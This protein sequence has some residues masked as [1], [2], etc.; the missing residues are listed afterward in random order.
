MMPTASILKNDRFVEGPPLSHGSQDDKPLPQ[1][2]FLKWFT[3]CLK[4][5][6]FLSV[7]VPCIC[8]EAW[9]LKTGSCPRLLYAPL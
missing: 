8:V 6:L 5:R 3:S 7:N 4:N 9:V 1:S 2:Y